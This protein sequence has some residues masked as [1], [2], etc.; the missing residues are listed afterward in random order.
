MIGRYNFGNNI[1]S[2]SFMLFS[3]LMERMYVTSMLFEIELQLLEYYSLSISHGIQV[4]VK[5]VSSMP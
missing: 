5:Y 4:W 1:C 3:N 2:S